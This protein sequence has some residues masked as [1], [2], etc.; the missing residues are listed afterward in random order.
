MDRPWVERVT[1]AFAARRHDGQLNELILGFDQMEPFGNVPVRIDNRRLDGFIDF[2]HKKHD[3]RLGC[4]DCHYCDD[5]VER[6]VDF[7]GDAP[8]YSGRIT[9]TLERYEQGAFRHRSGF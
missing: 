8:A 2:F 9:R 6:A 5:W 4:R 7:E 3:C 1:R